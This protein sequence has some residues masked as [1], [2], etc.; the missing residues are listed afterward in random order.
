MKFLAI[1][2]FS[3]SLVFAMVDINNAD[4]KELSSL[5]GVGVKKAEAIVAYRQLHCFKTVDEFSLVKGIGKKTIEKNRAN[6]S[7]GKCKIK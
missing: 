4:V 7:V 6:L 1:I 2:L 5:S 3:F